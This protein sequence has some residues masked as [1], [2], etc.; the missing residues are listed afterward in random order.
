MKAFAFIS[1]IFFACSTRTSHSLKCVRVWATIETGL[2]RGQRFSTFCA[3]DA[4][5]AEVK[6]PDVKKTFENI[7]A[8]RCKRF[9]DQMCSEVGLTSEIGG[10]DCGMFCLSPACETDT[11]CNKWSMTWQPPWC[12]SLLQKTLLNFCKDADKKKIDSHLND[13]MLQKRCFKGSECIDG[14]A[15]N[16]ANLLKTHYLLHFVTSV[17]LF[18]AICFT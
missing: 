5:S 8:V 10:E 3:E 17:G 14:L 6:V 18:V 16:S 15:S 12:C 4:N 7:T 9:M 11:D 1:L 2:C 13:L